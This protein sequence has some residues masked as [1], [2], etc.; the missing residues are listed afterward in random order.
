MQAENHV[1]VRWRPRSEDTER[2]LCVERIVNCTGPD[3]DA[4][5][6]RDPLLSSLVRNGYVKPDPLGLGLHTKPDCAV[7][8]ADGAPTPQLYYVGP[9]LRADHWEATAAAELRDF[10]DRAS[11]AITRSIDQR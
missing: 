6:S 9:M 11:L 8:G 7:V 1:E 5:R 4:S 2:A 3:Y 10:A